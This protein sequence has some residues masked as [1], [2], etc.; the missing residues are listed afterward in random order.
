MN[1]QPCVYLL[2]SKKNGTLYVGVTSDLVQRVWQHKNK[3]AS[4]FTEQH[5]VS[6]LVYFE[7]HQEMSAAIVREK[8]IKKWQRQWKVNL[9]EQANPD[10]EDLWPKIL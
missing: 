1:K 4:G 2:A 3:Q 9:I 10:W 8:H 5:N 7:Q 6:R